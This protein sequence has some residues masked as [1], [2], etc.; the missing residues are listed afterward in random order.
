MVALAPNRVDRGKNG[1]YAIRW[2]GAK[3]ERPMGKTACF[4]LLAG[5]IALSS[6]RLAAAQSNDAAAAEVLFTEG[7]KALDEKR[8]DEACRKFAE[9][10]HLEPAV[11][12]LMN[13]ATCEEKLGK[14][15]SAWQHWKEAIA[16]M[17]K[18]DDRVSFARGRVEELEKKLPRL[19]VVLEPGGDAR[20]FRDEVELGSAS[21]G[22]GLPVDPGSHS[23]T[24]RAAGR[25]PSTVTVSIAEGEQKRVEVRPGAVDPAAG[26]A[27]TRSRTLGWVVGGAGVVGI[28]VGAATSIILA[29]K[30]STVQAECPNNA[31]TPAGL[32]AANSGKSLLVVNAVAWVVGAV[33]LGVGGYLLLAPGPRPVTT[34]LAVSASPGGAGLSYRGSF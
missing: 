9:S 19:T 23:I 13:L 26:A 20:V 16:A 33:G 3:G 4:C 2:F 25:L 30:K 14:L 15:A 28:G 5:S 10:E 31:C 21:R 18:D 27:G 22:V 1:K 11:G 12:T 17:R 24:V 34:G 7:R 29:G 32:D 8:Y 6:A